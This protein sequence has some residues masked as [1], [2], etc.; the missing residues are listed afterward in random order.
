MIPPIDFVIP[1][2]L[3]GKVEQKAS[4]FLLLPKMI[5]ELVHVSKAKILILQNSSKSYLQP[6]D[7]DVGSAEKL[8]F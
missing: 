2:K 7:S 6:R 8:L 1:D 4:L 5:Q 3:N